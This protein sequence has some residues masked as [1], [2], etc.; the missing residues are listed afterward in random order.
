MNKLKPIKRLALLQ[1]ILKQLQI[2]VL[3]LKSLRLKELKIN[4]AL[5]EVRLINGLLKIEKM[6]MKD[7]LH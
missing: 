5:R 6:Q 7:Y 3:E 4:L 2:G 1:L